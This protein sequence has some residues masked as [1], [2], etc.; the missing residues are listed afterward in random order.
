MDRCD[1]PCIICASILLSSDERAYT[2]LSLPG[3]SYQPVIFVV[4]IQ[5]KIRYHEYITEG[6]E[7]MPAAFMGML[8]GDN[9]GKTIVKA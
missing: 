3:F 4:S 7:K 5:G 6:F 8:K 1:V 2:Y 9:L